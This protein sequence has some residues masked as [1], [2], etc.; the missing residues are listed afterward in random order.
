MTKDQL[1]KEMDTLAQIEMDMS[2]DLK[3]QPAL[4]PHWD[5]GPRPRRLASV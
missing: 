5:L 3:A 1:A 4:T 2:A